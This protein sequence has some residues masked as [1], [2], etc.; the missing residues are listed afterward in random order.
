MLRVLLVGFGYWGVNWA[1]VLSTEKRIIFVGV[2]DNCCEREAAFKLIYPNSSYFINYEDS[3]K[4][5]IDAVVVSTPVNTHFQISNFFLTNGIHVLCEKPL[6]ER[7][8]QIRTLNSVAQANKKILM[9]GQIFEY[10]SALIKV[11]SILDEGT[12]GDVLYVQMTRTGVGPVRDDTGVVSDLATHDISILN[13]LFNCLPEKVDAVAKS[14]SES[15][16]ADI[17]SISLSYS[18][19]LLATIFVSWMDAQKERKI[20]IVGTKKVLIFDDTK[21]QSKIKLI[22]KISSC[23]QDNEGV[24][25][26]YVSLNEPLRNQL[27]HFLDCILNDNPVR[28]GPESALRVALVLQSINT[29]I[30]SN[31]N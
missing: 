22:S 8:D 1:R 30:E 17:A 7:P 31:E 12:L 26:P 2:C 4:L 18:N 16:N 5:K 6:C 15:K 23:P 27:S 11:K 14:C 13:F 28:T 10:N 29:I 9:A 19:G 25:T 24:Y 3:I 21:I 20:K